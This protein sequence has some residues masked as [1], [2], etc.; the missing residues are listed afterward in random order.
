MPKGKVI[1]GA[2]ESLVDEGRD[3]G[4]GLLEKAIELWKNPESW[5]KVM[6]SSKLDEDMPIGHIIDT[7]ESGDLLTVAFMD[8]GGES[9]VKEIIHRSDLIPQTNDP[10]LNDKV[11][12]LGLDMNTAGVENID[13]L[14]K[15]GS[16][17]FVN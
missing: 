16:E 4:M 13:D 1:A 17:E 15:A 3:T 7:N 14:W 6:V 8:E 12:E 11:M 10:F 5:S 2:L 9:G